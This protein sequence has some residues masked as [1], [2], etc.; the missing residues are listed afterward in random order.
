MTEIRLQY[1]VTAAG[2]GERDDLVLPFRL[3]RFPVRGRLVRLGPAVDAVLG[4][5]A[6][7]DAVS[8]LLGEALVLVAML[9]PTLKFDGIITLQLQGEGPVSTVV[10]D[11][12]TPGA[13][14]GYA[15]F[16]KPRLDALDPATARKT[17]VSSL[18]GKG[19]LAFTLDPKFG[20]ERYQSVVPLEGRTLALCARDYFMQSEQLPTAL[21]LA[22]ARH[23][24]PRMGPGP[25]WRA[26]GLL[27]QK[28]P[29]TGGAAASPGEDDMWRYAEAVVDTVGD[30]ELV[31]PLLAPERLVRR[32]FPAEDV[33]VFASKR[34][35]FACRCSEE[36]LARILGAYS[37]RERSEMIE[38]DGSIHA[39]C[40]FCSRLYKVDPKALAAPA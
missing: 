35:Y 4:A 40:E 26:G 38:A 17:P 14:R 13:L 33:R 8:A 16:D 5:H 3:E 24:D 32:L 12:A 19:V 31:D 29:G 28:M 2:Q 1:G 27:T 11:F 20:R 21:K 15:A 6:Y 39:R 9:G 36:R 25:R 7:P 37:E 23:F 10:A 34:L 30:D 18:L 22:V